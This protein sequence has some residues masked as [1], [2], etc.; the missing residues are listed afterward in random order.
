MRAISPKRSRNRQAACVTR[1][2]VRFNGWLASS[3]PHHHAPP[4]GLLNRRTISAAAAAL[5][6]AG[7]LHGSMIEGNHAD[8]KFYELLAETLQSN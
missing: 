1:L 2:S 3:G 8:D 7:K 5:W 6:R 4:R